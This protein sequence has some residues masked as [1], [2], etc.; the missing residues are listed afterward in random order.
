M[1]IRGVG[2]VEIRNTTRHSLQSMSVQEGLLG[3]NFTSWIRDL[4][5]CALQFSIP[6]EPKLSNHL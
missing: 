6:E 3:L 4:L 5:I 2:E 1:G